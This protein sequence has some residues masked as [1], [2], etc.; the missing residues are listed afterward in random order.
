MHS[1]HALHTG[2]N[3]QFLSKN[4]EIISKVRMLKMDSFFFV[5][6]SQFLWLNC[7]GGK[8]KIQ[9]P[10]FL[11]SLMPVLWA[12]LGFCTVVQ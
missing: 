4:D 7:L 6:T 8:K 1:F 12:K 2:Q 10:S 5:K 3:S 11:N 9:K